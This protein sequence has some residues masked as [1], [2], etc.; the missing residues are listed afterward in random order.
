MRSMIRHGVGLGLAVLLAMGSV[1]GAEEGALV[2]F[3]FEA[4]LQEWNIPDWAK[5]STDDVGKILSTSDEVASHGKGSLQLLADFPGERWTGS[6]VEV[7]M[8]VTDWSKF[9]SLSMDVYLPA[10]APKGLGGRIILTVGEAWTWTEMNRTIALEPGRWTTMTA[11]LKPGS[12]DWKFF[13]EETFRT[14]I[15][16]VGLR[17]ESNKGPVYSGPVYLDHIRLGP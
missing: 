8:H 6:Y 9:G 16:K 11:N 5:E 7:M 10:S 1:A 17:I 2:I 14:D 12:L 3:D 4:G 15:R 13:P